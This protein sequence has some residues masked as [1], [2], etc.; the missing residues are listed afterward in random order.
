MEESKKGRIAWIENAYVFLMIFVIIGH[1]DTI[2]TKGKIIVISS[3]VK[4]FVYS[5]HMMAFS[6]LSGYLSQHDS[7]EKSFLKVVRKV[8]P[9]FVIFALIFSSLLSVIWQRPISFW[10]LPGGTWYLFSWACWLLLIGKYQEMMIS[11]LKE[12]YKRWMIWSSIVLAVLVGYAD[13]SSVSMLYRAFAL[14]PFFVIGYVVDL[15][16]FVSTLR[17]KKLYLVAILMI[18]LYLIICYSI[19]DRLSMVSAVFYGGNNNRLAVSTGP[20]FPLMYVVDVF[21]RLVF[22]LISLLMVFA[23]FIIV[24]KKEIFIG[25]LSLTKRA[26]FR[27]YSYL[28]HS[29]LLYIM[30]FVLLHVGDW[31]NLLIQVGFWLSVG[32]EY[33][34]KFICGVNQAANLAALISREIVTITFFLLFSFGVFWL[35][36]WKPVVIIFE[37]IIDSVAFFSRHQLPRWLRKRII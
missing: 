14:F 3:S 22:Y 33:Y 28:L 15:D 26:E 9:P 27:M 4:L 25:G 13:C 20:I 7:F 37:P 2:D 19:T 21:S 12:N 24:P 34:L 29:L 11:L 30:Y 23:F 35:T 10:D 16:S 32:V 8:I 6:L 1:L 5:F 36:T 18:S 17:K 31:S